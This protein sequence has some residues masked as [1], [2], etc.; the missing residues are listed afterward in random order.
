MRG[1]FT[2]LLLIVI[3]SLALAHNLGYFNVNLARLFSTWWPI[4]LIALG[5]AFFVTPGG[6]R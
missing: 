5:L 4:L 1:H 2:A 6:K 3:G